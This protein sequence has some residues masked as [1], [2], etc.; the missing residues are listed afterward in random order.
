MSEAED[1]RSSSDSSPSASH[2]PGWA[3]MP[4]PRHSG[5]VCV[6]HVCLEHITRKQ[7]DLYDLFQVI[8]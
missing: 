1:Y 7:A 3:A 4:F 8:N 2:C 5:E 6:Q